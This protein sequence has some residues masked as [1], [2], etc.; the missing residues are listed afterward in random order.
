MQEK[1]GLLLPQQFPQ[2]LFLFFSSLFLSLAN[3]IRAEAASEP[4][5]GEEEIKS[6][7][8]EGGR[9]RCPALNSQAFL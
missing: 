8:E 1:F 4:L 7:Q 6:E 5:C 9:K 2:F 3:D